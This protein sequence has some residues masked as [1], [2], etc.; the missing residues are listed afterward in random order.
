MHGLIFK[1]LQVFVQDTYGQHT[2]EEIAAE[3]KLDS[4]DFEAM[5]SYE[6]KDLKG[7]VK[8]S[9]RILGKPCSQF[10]E[11]I[12][13][14][15]VSHPNRE[16]LRRLLRFGGVN[17]IDFLHSLDELPGRARLAVPNLS[18]PEMELEDIGAN[19]F[20]LELA[21]D[22]PSFGLVMIGVLRAMADDYGTLVLLDHKGLDGDLKQIEI[23]VV[24]TEFAKGRDFELGGRATTAGG[25]A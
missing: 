16:G 7:L 8:A 19:H 18:L 17:F 5:L 1:T 14:Y 13:T 23:T 24:E 25:T 10:L 9:E 15:L 4:A 12:G 2:W 20:V 3:A 6:R 11:D 22:M 21:G